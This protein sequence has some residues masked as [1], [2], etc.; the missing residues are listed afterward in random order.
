MISRTFFAM[1]LAAMTLATAPAH[2]ASTVVTSPQALPAKHD[3]LRVFLGGSIDM[4]TAP[5]WQRA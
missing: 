3:R 4:G 2:A 1:V 5:D